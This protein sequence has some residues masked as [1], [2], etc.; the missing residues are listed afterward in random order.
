MRSWRLWKLQE[1]KKKNAHKYP[2]LMHHMW[3]LKKKKGF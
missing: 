3:C 1:G 2:S